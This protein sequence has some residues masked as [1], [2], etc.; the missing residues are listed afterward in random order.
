MDGHGG[1]CVGLQS[2]RLV[3]HDIIDAIENMPRPFK[4]DLYDL[5]KLLA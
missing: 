2:N 4:Q 5:T 3:H 1:R